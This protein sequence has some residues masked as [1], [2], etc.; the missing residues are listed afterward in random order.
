M[1]LKDKDGEHI[2]YYKYYLEIHVGDDFIGKN[3]MVRLNDDLFY[4]NRNIKPIKNEMSPARDAF[5]TFGWDN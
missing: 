3:E 1:P 4:R 5:F 2:G